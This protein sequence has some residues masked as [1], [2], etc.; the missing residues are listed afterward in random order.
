MAMKSQTKRML[1]VALLITAFLFLSLFLLSSLFDQR[2]QSFLD[3]ETQ[4]MYNSLNEM[5][6]FML[7]SET[8][9]NEMACLAFDAKLKELDTSVWDLGRKIDQYRVASEEFTKDPY[10]LEQKKVFNENEVFYMM[11]LQKVKQTC[12]FKQ[13][14]IAFFYQNSEDCKKCDDQSFVL[15]DI[16]DE[17]DDEV[18]IFSY[19][20]D[21]NLTSVNLLKTYYKID[22][23]PCI[24]I[25]DRAYC[26]MFDKKF[27]MEKICEA[28]PT[29]SACITA[30]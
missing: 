24:I 27:V 18:S 7:M 16:N 14:V 21:L 19:D 8:Y 20:A 29:I 5:Q 2:R 23:Y 15:T 30:S 17:I 22:Q 26:G 9:G 11:L 10:Y 6:T 12:G 25:N 1:V 4:K 28:E 13:V 3:S